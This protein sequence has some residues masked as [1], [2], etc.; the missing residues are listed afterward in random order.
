MSDTG[1]SH[2]QATPQPGVYDEFSQKF[3]YNIKSLIEDRFPV[4]KCLRCNNK[5]FYIETLPIEEEYFNWF[6]RDVPIENYVPQIITLVCLNC[7]KMEQYDS[8]ILKQTSG[9]IEEKP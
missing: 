1:T 2:V 6:R 4:M 3:K 7:G 9:P 5:Y 8:S